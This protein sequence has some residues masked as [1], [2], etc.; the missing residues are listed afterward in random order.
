MVRSF[1]VAL[2]LLLVSAVAAAC[3]LCIGTAA[4]SSSQDLD[5]LPHA[6]LAL[7]DGQ[8]FRVI[9][10]IKGT[11]PGTMLTE[12]VVPD[13]GPADK[14]LLLVR[15]DAWPMWVSLG[16]VS[17]RHAAA[18]RELAAEHPSEADTS[19]WQRRLDVAIPN[20]EN[21]DA[22]LAEIAYAESAGAPY[23][24]LRAA[25]HLLDARSLR[26][27][28]DD[29]SLVARLPLYLLL[30]GIAGNS[31]DADVIESK[32]AAAREAGI[33]TNVS[34]MLAADLELRGVSRVK[35]LEDSYLLDPSRTTSEI[36]AALLAL[37]V[38]AN[39]GG[40][41]PRERAIEAYRLFMR[42]HKDMAGIVAPDLAAW[43]YWD[44]APEFAALL[45]ANV[46]LQGDSRAAIVAYLQQ[47]PLRWSE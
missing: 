42:E 13:P 21:S 45:K 26:G 14:A 35:W 32:L 36:Q 11:S 39:S 15:D 4:R 47:S 29:Q 17:A 20:L 10:V 6:V 40:P 37:S 22:L 1:F 3:P 24:A 27:Y 33:A 46:R 23:A 34:S 7:P 41:I 31:H 16:S 5:E 19:A 2:P 44:A 9:D 43:E 30:I 12:V 28:V 25:R 38:Q 8:Q 18:L